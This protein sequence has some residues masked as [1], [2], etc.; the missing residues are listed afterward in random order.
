MAKKYMAALLHLGSN[1]WAR[2][3]SQ[4]DPFPKGRGGYAT[5]LVCQK[6]EWV[7]LT[8]EMANLGYNMLLIDMAEGVC[9]DSHPE[10]AIEGS[11]SKEEFKKDLERLRALGITPIPKFN[12]SLGHSAWL[13]DYLYM[14][15]TPTWYKVCADLIKEVCEMFDTPEFFH[16]GL[17]EEEYGSQAN[18]P[19]AVI[20]NKELKCHDAKYLF[21]VCRE[22]GTRPWIWVDPNTIDTFGGE[23]EFQQIVPKDVL[24]S[25]W[26]YGR[27]YYGPNI[28]E[29]V[30]PRCYLYKKIGD[31]G[32]EQIPTTSNWGNELNAKQT[33]DFCKRFTEDSIVG[34]M[35][36]SWLFTTKEEHYG[37]M[38]CLVN[39]KYAYD[40]IYGE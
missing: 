36:A 33:M 27:C 24:I 1:M 34:Y 8:T 2:P 30:A 37:N 9:Y 20:R 11:W 29:D 12:F 21:D 31:W 17:E 35:C 7:S 40:D 6:D 19:I 23:E 22:C 16:L 18:F 15:G 25:N 32:Y 5:K 4:Y 39:M 3:N 10:L 13:K 26:F 14:A 38:D 28:P